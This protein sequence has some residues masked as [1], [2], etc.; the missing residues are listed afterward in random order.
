MIPSGPELFKLNPKPKL[1]L[2]QF[3]ALYGYKPT[4]ADD[5]KNAQRNILGFSWTP[6][7]MEKIYAAFYKTMDRVAEKDFSYTSDMV[8]FENNINF[9]VICSKS[10]LTYKLGLSIFGS[11]GDLV[12]EFDC[13]CSLDIPDHWELSHRFVKEQYRGQEIGS[14]M[15]KIM[16]MTVKHEA[17]N[18]HR[19]QVLEINARQ[20]GVANFA[21][22]NGYEFGTEKD[23]DNF[24]LVCRGDRS[25][26]LIA[27]APGARGD[28]IERQGYIYPVNNLQEIAK[29][30]G[31]GNLNPEEIWALDLNDFFSPRGLVHSNEALKIVFK[32]KITPQ[33]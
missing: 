15:L 33:D 7:N 31:R 26:I 6:E 28:D 24:N 30:Q 21:L 16:E 23:K 14:K 5:V 22:K 2:E 4:R 27:T 3:Y 8:R 32:K 19:D 1:S 9:K 20:L 13:I 29:N 17:R 11:E 10:D 18:N 12:S 25:K